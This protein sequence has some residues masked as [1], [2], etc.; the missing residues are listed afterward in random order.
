MCLDKKT[1]QRVPL[2]RDEDG[3]AKYV[4]NGGAIK[5]ED[6]EDRDMEHHPEP[7]RDIINVHLRAPPL[8]NDLNSFVLG[9]SQDYEEDACGRGGRRDLDRASGAGGPCRVR[10]RP[11]ASCTGT[12]RLSLNSSDWLSGSEF[13]ATR[14]VH[15]TSNFN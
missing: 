8:I 4:E 9:Q 6:A 14:L 7:L 5:E 12:N 1:E 10:F 3:S 13:Q 11:S 2:V 15:E